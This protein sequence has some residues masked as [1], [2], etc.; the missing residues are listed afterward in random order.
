MQ[1]YRF[2]K[3][4][5]WEQ[6]RTRRK[7]D[8]ARQRHEFRLERLEQE[9]REREERMRKKKAALKKSDSSDDPKKAAIKA[10]LERVKK[11]QAQRP[12]E[13]TNVSDLTEE[14]QR[15]IQEVKQ[16]RADNKPTE[17]TNKPEA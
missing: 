9:K 2:A 16:R 1:Y 12:V 3:T 7:S 15:K 4:E 17:Q 11:R 6:E 13:K 8:T 10:A 14:Q 5:I